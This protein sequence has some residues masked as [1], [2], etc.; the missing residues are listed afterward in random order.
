MQRLAR[1]PVR[2]MAHRLLDALLLV[3]PQLTTLSPNTDW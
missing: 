2:D 1:G 3:A